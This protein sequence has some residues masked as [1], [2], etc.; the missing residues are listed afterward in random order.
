MFF[1]EVSQALHDLEHNNFIENAVDSF[2]KVMDMKSEYLASMGI[3]RKLKWRCPL[4][5]FGEELEEHNVDCPKDA[6]YFQIWNRV[7]TIAVNQQAVPLSYDEEILAE[8]ISISAPTEIEVPAS[9]LKN[10]AIAREFAA[11]LLKG[12]E[13]DAA[14]SQ[15][16]IEA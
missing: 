13:D 1:A 3:G 2:N 6:V 5:L 8:E 10:M 15:H 7:S 9:V 14:G 12:R 4:E 16:H 11:S